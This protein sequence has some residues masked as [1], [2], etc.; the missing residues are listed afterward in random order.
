MKKQIKYKLYIIRHG[1]TKGNLEGRYVGRTDE[2]LTEESKRNLRENSIKYDLPGPDIILASPLKRCVETAE[3]L[4]PG[5]KIRRV[6]GFAECNFG[7]FEYMNYAELNGDPEYQ[8]YIDSGGTAAFP[9]GEDKEHFQDRCVNAFISAMDGILEEENCLNNKYINNKDRL[10]ALV[11]HGGTIMAL[12]DKF[13]VP[14]RDYFDWH[15]GNGE[16][17]EAWLE[18]SYEPGRWELSITEAVKTVNTNSKYK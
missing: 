2:S 8:R 7:K 15:V 16:G 12:M 10:L 17:Y 3:L 1:A 13:A 11:V 14:H 5:A 18:C 6:D 4:F 9:G